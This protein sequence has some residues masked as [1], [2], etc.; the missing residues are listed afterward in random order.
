LSILTS[1][2]TVG[3]IQIEIRVAHEHGRVGLALG[4]GLRQPR[5]FAS[6]AD[7][8]DGLLLHQIPRRLGGLGHQ[9]HLERQPAQLPVRADN[10]V[11]HV[12]QMPGQRRIHPFAHALERRRQILRP[13]LPRAHAPADEFHRLVDRR[14]L[15]QINSLHDHIRRI[16]CQRKSQVSGVAGFLPL[17]C[18][19]CE[20]VVSILHEIDESRLRRKI[21]RD[22]HQRQIPLTNCLRHQP[23]ALGQ[24]RAKPVQ[25]VLESL[26]SGVSFE[27]FQAELHKS[28]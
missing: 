22:V 5:H 15:A 25:L 3:Q 19:G 12:R 21:L 8:A 23:G 13:K 26:S 28:L 18:P 16:L 24:L 2:A 9:Q 11:R 4:G 17:A 20:I 6:A 1:A 14:R 27:W 7:V 10:Q